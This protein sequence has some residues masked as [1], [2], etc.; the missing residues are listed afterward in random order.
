MQDHQEILA[1]ILNR[2]F[3]G[4]ATSFISIFSVVFIYKTVLEQANSQKTALM[5]VVLFSFGFYFV[6]LIF[7]LIAEEICHRY[8]LKLSIVLGQILLIG[9]VV[10]LMVSPGH[11]MLI[12]LSSALF[13]AS[14]G[15]YWFAFHGLLA[16]VSQEQ[17]FG[18]EAGLSNA[19]PNVAGLFMPV[20]GGFL[21][22]IA[23][24]QGLFLGGLFFT[25]LSLI[26]IIPVKER[27]VRTDTFLR[28]ILG[29]FKTQKAAFWGHFGNNF[30]TGIY[31]AI[32]PLYIF[33]ILGK[34]L[35]MGGFFS[36][37]MICAAVID[38]LVGKVIDTKGRASSLVAGS[39]TS[40]VVW[41]GRALIGNATGLLFLETADYLASAMTGIPIDVLTYK[42]AFD[43]QATGRA[44]LFRE[45]ALSLGAVFGCLVVLILIL[46]NLKFQYSFFIAAIFTLF[47]LLLI[48][49]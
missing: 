15:L 26:T 40:F 41:L 39:L 21:V 6:K 27:V 13:G 17:R 19:L 37:A 24:Y 8:G 28:E 23:G 47:S 20:L 14:S 16:K 36:L 42:K 29:L 1:L 7:D 18:R 38:L 11:L 32:F 12:A 44:V 22:A 45:F 33:F 5:A 49:K 48:R 35:S 2:T 30:P 34:E 31:S 3:R 25:G 43:S 4:L 10:C 46:A 9:C